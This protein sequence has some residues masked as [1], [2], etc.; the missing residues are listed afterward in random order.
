MFFFENSDASCWK[1]ETHKLYLFMIIV[2]KDFTK[3]NIL[4][5][6]LGKHYVHVLAEL[7]KKV[8]SAAPHFR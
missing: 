5:H 2:D 8:F 4:D 6:K 7:N 1:S 3:I